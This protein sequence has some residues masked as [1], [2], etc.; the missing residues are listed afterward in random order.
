M[1]KTELK[2]KY[3]NLNSLEINNLYKQIKLNENRPKCCLCY[4]K[5]KQLY[6]IDGHIEWCVCSCH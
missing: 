6:N 5:R 1:T 4:G 3:P 2:S